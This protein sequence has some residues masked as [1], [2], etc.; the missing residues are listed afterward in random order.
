MV[1]VPLTFA[2]TRPLSIAAIHPLDFGRRQQPP[3][4]SGLI[5]DIKLF[6]T[7]FAGGFV[8]MS[9]YLA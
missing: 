1:T 4:R 8:F 9:V 3:V 7:F 6:A 2:M 5:D